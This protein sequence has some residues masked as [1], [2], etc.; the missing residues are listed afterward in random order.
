[1]RNPLIVNF[2]VLL[3]VYSLFIHPAKGRNVDNNFF[4]DQLER[5]LNYKKNNVLKELFLQ[6]SFK[7]FEKKY[8]IFKRKYKDAKWSI[9]TIKSQPKNKFLDIEIKSTKKIADQIFNL[10]SKQIVELEIHKNKIKNYQVLKEYSILNSQG[11][12]L[13]IELIAPDQVLTG[14]RYEFNLIIKKPLDDSLIATGIIVLKNKDSSQISQEFFGIKPNESG[15]I[16]KYIQAP[17]E[18][19]LQTIS[20]IIAHPKGIYSIS[21]TIKVDLINKP[22]FPR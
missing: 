14:E 16:F 19:G 18:P 2:I 21:K 17:L 10:N 4:S 7:K 11:S 6:K 9:K 12:P 5:G 22:A 8:L 20:A 1:M 15:G 13:T 3:S